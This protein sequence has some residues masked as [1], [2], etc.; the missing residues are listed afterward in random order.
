M[1]RHDAFHHLS[2][3]GTIRRSSHRENFKSILLDIEHNIFRSKKCGFCGQGLVRNRLIVHKPKLLFGQLSR[4][5]ERLYTAESGCRGYLALP[6]GI[7][8]PAVETSWVFRLK[9]ARIISRYCSS[10]VQRLPADETVLLSRHYQLLHLHLNRMSAPRHRTRRLLLAGGN[11]FRR[12]ST[13]NCR[14]AIDTVYTAQR[15]YSGLRGR[16]VEY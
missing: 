7:T 14:T 10:A 13:T 3:V 15:V 6:R 8:A 11:R 9:T 4:F 16:G 12:S 2:G 5:E 1:R